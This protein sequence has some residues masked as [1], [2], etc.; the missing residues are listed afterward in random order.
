MNSHLESLFLMSI[1]PQSSAPGELAILKQEDGPVLNTVGG[2]QFYFS[3]E[4]RLHLIRRKRTADQR[5][6]FRITPEFH[7][8][9]KVVLAPVPEPETI[10]RHKINLRRAHD[11]M[12]REATPER[13][14]TARNVR[15]ARARMSSGESLSPGIMWKSVT[16]S[17]SACSRASM[18][19]S[20]S[21][22]M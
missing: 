8:Q 19:I 10:C 11:Q 4:P 12:A 1:G 3:A 22:S 21:V 7:G 5:S 16:P 18:L 9:R 6:H 20:C 13:L 17:D 2:H 15:S 14:P